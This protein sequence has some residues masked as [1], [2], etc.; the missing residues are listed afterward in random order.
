MPNK[1]SK[2]LKYCYGGKSL[3][4]PAKKMHSCQSSKDNLEKSYTEEKTKHTPS[5]YSPFTNCSFWQQET[6]LIVTKVKI[7]WKSFVK[8]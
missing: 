7:V 5:G 2:I 4:V 6:N 3:N 8:T 1:D